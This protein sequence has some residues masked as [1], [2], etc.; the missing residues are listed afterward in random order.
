MVV[1]QVELSAQAG[2]EQE[3]LAFVAETWRVLEPSKGFRSFTF[4]RGV[5]QPSKVYF[6]VAWDSLEDHKA[7]T[8]GAAFQD[9]SGKLRGFVTGAAAHHFTVEA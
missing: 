5:E 7:A 1:E 9:W 8:Q 3:L 4:G 6:V 2:R